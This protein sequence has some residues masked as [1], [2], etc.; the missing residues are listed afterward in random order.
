MKRWI[1]RAL[2]VHPGDLG[3]GT[4]LCSCLFLIISTYKIGGVAGAA[5][6][7]SR[8][9]ARQLAYA[10][11]SSSVL[12]TLLVAGYVLVA[13]RVPLRGLLLGSTLFFA[14]NC[15]L[16]WALAHYHFHL[17]LLFPVF[18]VWVKIFGVLAGTQ[19]WTLANYVLTTREAKRIFGMVG[20]GAIAGG[21][22]AGFLSKTIAKRF[23]TESLLLAMTLFVFIC[24]GLVIL[25]WRS[26]RVLVGDAQGKPGESAET[27][28]RN[29]LASMRLLFASPY[30]RAIAAVICI[31]NFVVTLTGWQFLA[32]GQQFLVKKDAMAIF[33]GD[34]YFYVG[35]LGLLFQLLL[36]ARFLRR[37][38]IGTALFV[39]PVTVLMG[40]GGLLVLG[41]LGSAVA[42]KGGDQVL[43]YSVD[44]STAELL[45]LPIAT[46]VKLQVKWFIDTVIWRLGDGLSGLIVLIFATFLQF[47][48]RQISWVVVLVVRCW[49]V[50]VSV[51]VRQS[52]VPRL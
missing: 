36:T 19:I 44:K 39:L 52:V 45:Y 25:V 26:G 18:Y 50:A 6:F 8:F 49:L 34:F 22:F 46:R 11:I 4:L 1:E 29:L 30:L 7:L 47:S 48:P 28:S 14:S 41:T 24:A 31:S 43:R 12:V 9:Q 17:A 20:G 32:I 5:L 37:F 23:G 35:V 2:N 40:S 15:A 27:S 42:L 10:D 13:R 38:G 3:R 51:A 16:F 21:I 33:F